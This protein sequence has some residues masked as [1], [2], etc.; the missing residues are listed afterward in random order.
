MAD[1]YLRPPIDRFRMDDFARIEE[2]AEVGYAYARKEIRA[3][4]ETGR[5]QALHGQMRA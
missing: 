5:L 2:I 3:W 4:K 1:F